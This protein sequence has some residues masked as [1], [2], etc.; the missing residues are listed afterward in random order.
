M[1]R[2]HKKHDGILL[3]EDDGRAR[4]LVW[5]EGVLYRLGLFK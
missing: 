4:F 2:F 3:I 1:R 5:W